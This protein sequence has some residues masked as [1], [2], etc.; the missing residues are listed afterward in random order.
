MTRTP[1]ILG[2]DGAWL[3]YDRHADS[4]PQHPRRGRRM[5]ASMDPAGGRPRPITYHMDSTTELHPLV[6]GRLMDARVQ[7]E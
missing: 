5:A 4:D 1:N 7:G 6:E 2:A 3:R